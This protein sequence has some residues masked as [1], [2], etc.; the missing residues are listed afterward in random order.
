M[1]MVETAAKQRYAGVRCYSC[2][3][4]I[5]VPSRISKKTATGG[6]DDAEPVRNINSSVFNLRCKVCEK[7]NFYGPRDV[8]EIEGAPRLTR[9]KAR[10]VGSL[11]RPAVKLA[12]SANA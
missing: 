1:M 5:P 11:L 9:L 10:P 8:L 2:G 7:E 12:R 3:E 4:A 6:S